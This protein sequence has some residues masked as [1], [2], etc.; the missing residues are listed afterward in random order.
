[1]VASMVG[2]LH[3]FEVGDVV[4]RWVVVNVVDDP[5]LR[6]GTVVVDPDNAVKESFA[7]RSS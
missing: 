4:V 1:M 3:E 2:G 6:D 5:A 7:A